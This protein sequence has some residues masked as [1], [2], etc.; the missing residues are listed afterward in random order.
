MNKFKSIFLTIAV[1]F[2]FSTIFYLVYHLAEPKAYDFMVKNVLVEKLPFDNLK[3]VHGSD[4]IVLVV[5]DEKTVEKYRWP[6]KR[7]I[8]CKIFE[9]FSLSLC[10]K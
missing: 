4:D 7:E 1:I 10:E 9:Y 8:N 2:I 6:W 3:K 5:I